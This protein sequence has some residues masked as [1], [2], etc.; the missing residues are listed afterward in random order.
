MTTLSGSSSSAPAAAVGAAAGD[1]REV[2]RA[3]VHDAVWSLR[4]ISSLALLGLAAFAVLMPVSTAAVPQSSVFTLAYT[5]DQLRFRFFAGQLTSVVLL[6]TVVYGVGLGVALFRFA[7]VRDQAAAFFSLGLGRT[8]LY[9]TRLVVGVLALAAGVLVPLAVSLL[10]NCLALGVTPGVTAQCVA[11]GAC[12][13]ALGMV[14][15]TASALS[16]LVAGTVTEAL[17]FC[18][19]LL[20]SVTVVAWGLNALMSRLLIG[21]AY[22][23]LTSSRTTTVAPSLVSATAAINPLL[24][25]NTFLRAH[26]IFW[27]HGLVPRPPAVAWDTP[28][29]WLLAVAGLAVAGA[30]C[31]ERR[32]TEKAGMAGSAPTV[33]LFAGGV[34]G[35][36]GF[37]VVFHLLA[38]AGVGPAIVAGLA[39]LVVVGMV[40]LRGPQRE[41]T[42]WS[43]TVAIVAAQTVVAL[44]VVAVVADGGLGYSARVPA[45]ARVASVVVSYV[46][47]PNYL[48]APVTASSL[49][50]SYYFAASY[51]YDSASAVRLVERVHRALIADAQQPLA[52]AEGAFANTVVPYDVV[53]TYRLRGGGHL[54]R[55]YD[56]A[57]LT[58]LAA[59]L[60]LDDTAG[61]R[62]LERALITGDLG[63]LS[64]SVATAV[65]AAPAWGAYRAGA[66][67]LADRW[68]GHPVTV[69][70]DAVE[71]DSL[72]AAIAHDVAARP[73]ADRYFPVQAALGV[74]AFTQDPSAATLGYTYGD[75][76]VYVTPDMTSTIAFLR[77]HDLAGDFAFRDR[78]ESLTFE[79]YDPYGGIVRVTAPTSA[80]FLGYRSSMAQ[81][82]WTQQDFGL[83]L[84]VSDPAKIAQ[85]VPRL[86]DTYFMS[87]GG[88]LVAAQLAGS[89]AAA[90]CYLPAAEAPA[91]VR[92]GAL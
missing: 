61:V 23:A 89:S 70:L 55:Y 87:D 84:T 26:A 83:R 51:T 25:F 74:I 52:V 21:N 22:G 27:R 19:A 92:K 56:R 42:P 66:I 47:S 44:V 1:V 30:V 17:A 63:G 67:V 65:V 40:L 7:L 71:R 57:R 37:A 77:S 8:T 35:F 31:V 38:P 58:D 14:S 6:V 53:I 91:Y 68:F 45:P 78:L 3:A 54:T 59:L 90:Y 13:F 85:L 18:A 15:L 34:L 9:C 41:R 32:H 12:L 2:L 24:A 88:Y 10:L 79:K 4:R 29:V 50:R 64:P 60:A 62:T 49:G 43:R 81:D 73:A 46:G 28:A 72:L 82:F 5:H 20:G 36:G 76:L 86:R 39:A 48:A 16:C 75:A 69:A 80:Y 33:D 11:V